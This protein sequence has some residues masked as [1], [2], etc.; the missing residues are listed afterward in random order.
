MAAE[1]EQVRIVDFYTEV[2]LPA[3]AERL[4]QAFPEFGW[5]RD[6]RGW[7]A[8]NEEHTH[9]RLGV[10]AERVVAHGP[11]PRGFLVHGGEPMLWTA[12]LVGGEPP[13][14]AEFVRVVAELADRAGVDSAPIERETPRNRRA[15]LFEEFFKLAQRELV[16]DRGDTARAYLEQR[17]FPVDAIETSG[18]G[19]VPSIVLT[20]RALRTSGYTDDETKGSGLFADGRWPGRLCG[21][22]RDEWGRVGTF[23]AR[24]IDDADSDGARYLYLRG[25]ERTKLPPYGLQRGVRELALVE[26]FFD[27]HQV[28][29][30]GIE[31]SAAI[32]GTATN[33]RLF[34]RLS[35]LGIRELTLCFDADDAGRAATGRAIEN[36][37]RAVASPS[38]FVAT[39]L[40]KDPDELVR[41]H[42]IEAWH[43]QSPECGVAWRAKELLGDVGSTSPVVARREALA[44]AGAWLGS[45]PPRLA[46]EQEDGLRAVSE[47]SG[48]S[49]EAVRRAFQARFFRDMSP[50]GSDAR[51][52]CSREVE[53]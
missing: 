39:P 45:L 44:H 6:A 50:R 35:R 31:N 49:V 32:G 11:V 52:S 21:A 51:P 40:A 2:V 41:K 16:S 37:A 15:E 22:W 28:R 24:A 20:E 12:Y 46:L 48:Y 18:L 34:E 4:D 36:A 1:R 7:I 3:L 17:G 13:R 30:H 25:A 9:G 38:I 47:R 8:T 42:G 27:H 23:W 5:R 10:R 33:P 19:V 26:G 43:Q 29:A 53:F 14:G